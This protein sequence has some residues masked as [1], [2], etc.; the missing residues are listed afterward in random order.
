MIPVSKSP[1]KEKEVATTVSIEGVNEVP[2]AE[3][4]KYKEERKKKKDDKV[5]RKSSTLRA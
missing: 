5:F 4:P 1:A 2:K 3:K